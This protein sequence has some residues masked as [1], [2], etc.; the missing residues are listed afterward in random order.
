MYQ[1]RAVIPKQRRV[2]RIRLWQPV[3]ERADAT[4]FELEPDP[5]DCYVVVDDLAYRR[6]VLDVAPWPRLDEQGRL[7]F[8]EE[9]E[10]R[11][12]A[13]ELAQEAFDA[14]RVE[15]G[16]VLRPLRVGDAFQV[17]HIAESIGDWVIGADV[18]RPAR[19]AARLALFAAV[20]P[21]LEPE[22]AQLLPPVI[23]EPPLVEPDRG[24]SGPGTARP[25][26]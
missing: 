17:Q 8:G 22:E 9:R 3:V 24:P 23:E 20:A 16:Q 19:D 7:T 10:T 13:L 12:A 15:T 6:V 1:Q 4:V 14:A 11:V 18:T 5:S 21:R 2:P 25:A 26:V